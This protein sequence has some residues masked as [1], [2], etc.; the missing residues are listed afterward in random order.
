MLRLRFSFLLLVAVLCLGM[1]ALGAVATATNSEEDSPAALIPPVT[2]SVVDG[3][4]TAP[5]LRPFPFPAGASEEELQRIRERIDSWRKR[6]QRP[7]TDGSAPFD[8]TALRERLRQQFHEMSQEKRD[9]IRADMMRRMRTARPVPSVEPVAA[10][11]VDE[12]QVAPANGE[13]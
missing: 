4:A 10:V 9:R 6:E 7:G 11:P 5:A 8:A 1:L 3:A 13:L 12:V 2:A